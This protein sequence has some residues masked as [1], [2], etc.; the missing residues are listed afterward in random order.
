[1]R[2]T[3][4]ELED[5]LVNGE[6]AW[7]ELKESLSG[8]ATDQIREV[9]CSFA[10][11]LS[12]SNK[13][14]VVFVGVKDKGGA[15]GF[16]ADDQA[17]VTLSAMK[18]DGNI[19]PVPSMLVEKRTVS[20][21][22]LAV[23]TVLPSNSPPVRCKGRIQVRI[24]PRRGL[25]SAQDEH[26]LNE[27]RRSKN[28][29]FDIQAIEELGISALNLR[30]FEEEYLPNAFAPEVIAMNGRT[31]VERLA[32]T[33]MLSK[34]NDG[35]ATVLGCLV[36]GKSTRD[37][38]PCA[39]IQFLRIDGTELTDPIVDEADIDGPIADLLRRI[40][41]KIT[42]QIKTA[43]DLTSSEKEART[44]NYPIAAVQQL[45]R[46]AVMHR[47]YE[48]TNAPVRITWYND[49][50]EIMNPG[51]PFGQVTSQNFGDAGIT[52]Y[53][54]PNLAEAM[55]VLGYVQRFGVGIATARKLL[56]LAGHKAPDFQV[57]PN[58]VMVTIWGKSE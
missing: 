23:V 52:D 9:I 26:I 4:Q 12:G 45:V 40:D 48:A 53:R 15:S 11:D 32:A 42:A 35:S 46:N 27:K 44:P 34:A 7:C 8:N 33:K 51:G 18:S 36:L 16:V 58:H 20:G 3:D 38:I 24:G 39:Y 19:L 25:A 17:L 21:L 30:I 29:P 22:Q 41:E 5:L 10:N 47:S 49:R 55:K 57:N 50:I 2:L 13:P 43:V 28:T 56:S 54:N 1:M 31:I 37:I 6:S 14:G